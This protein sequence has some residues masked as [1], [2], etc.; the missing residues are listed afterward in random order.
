M[1]RRKK[2]LGRRSKEGSVE[3]GATL[4]F[5]HSAHFYPGDKKKMI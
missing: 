5:S 1:V 4:A 2:S 3:K